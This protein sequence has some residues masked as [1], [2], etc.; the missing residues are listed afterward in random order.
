MLRTNPASEKFGMC[1][2]KAFSAAY[3]QR[4]F[5][6]NLLAKFN[7][8]FAFDTSRDC[9]QSDYPNDLPDRPTDVFVCR[10]KHLIDRLNLAYEILA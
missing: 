8:L 9:R 2:S 1:Q 10:T 4:R 7:L 3:L 5:I 6:F